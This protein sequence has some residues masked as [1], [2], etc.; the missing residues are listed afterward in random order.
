M[1]VR[2]TLRYRNVK[3]KAV[4]FTVDDEIIITV[5]KYGGRYP[6]LSLWQ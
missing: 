6:L 4:E 2:D 1:T 3:I 5:T